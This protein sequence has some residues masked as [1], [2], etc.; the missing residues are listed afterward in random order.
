MAL[1]GSLTTSKYDGRYYKLAWTATQDISTNKSK[2]K[3]TLSCHGGNSS[4]YAERTLKVVVAG[5]TVFSKTSRKERYTG[6]I[7]TGTVTV[8]H[9]TDG[10]KSFSASVKAAVYTS[11]VNCTGSKTFTLDQIPRAATITSAPDFT[12]EDN[13]VLNYS[14]SAGSSVTTLQACIAS[15]DGMT[16]YAPYRDI[17]KTGTSYTFNLTEAEREA[18]RKAC[19]NAKSMTV[20][21]YVKTD[22]DGETYR[23]NLAKT[24]TI[25]NAEPD[26][27][28]TAEATDEL[29][30]SLLGTSQAVI[31]GV[32]DLAYT[33]TA[34]AKKHATITSYKVVNGSA[35]QTTAAG[36]F[37]DVENGNTTA[38][39]T[40]SRGYTRTT[41]ISFGSVI[42]YIYP[43]ATLKYSNVSVEG[44]VDLDL[45][46][47]CYS[48]S[49]LNTPNTTTIE[50]RY[51]PNDGDWSDYIPIEGATIAD[52]GYNIQYT[53]EGLDYHKT[54][55]IEYRVVD[56]IGSVTS[57]YVEIVF[58]PLF[59]W[60]EG[61]F[62][63]NV[64]VIF[65]AG[66]INAASAAAEGV[67]STYDYVIESGADSG[68]RYRKWKSGFIEAWFNEDINIATNTAYGSGF[69]NGGTP[70]YDFPS[71]LFTT[72]P[73][74]QLS[75]E[76]SNAQLYDAHIAA[77]SATRLTYY[78]SS[79][80]AH[81]AST[82]RIQI[83]AYGNT[84]V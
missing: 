39:I 7:D 52:N 72:K 47:K 32:T 27:R 21:F 54:Y 68:W 28:I 15:S 8:S 67:E 65:S 83:Y 4:W 62:N 41:N 12:D 66:F 29:S 57:N 60:G 1:S 73:S 24:L 84:E 61:D 78:I 11:S 44:R 26:A 9:N 2:I 3:W 42:K 50:I 36:T 80:Q 48:G 18:L 20:R 14:N 16:I 81:D 45:S 38:T 35:T 70:Y 33:V 49:F 37:T 56:K 71:N 63:F 22:I 43:T 5:V 76:P 79:M 53:L 34:T 51:K 31:L 46:G 10:T 82:M 30:L 58:M 23:K 17:S 75:V 19:T 69:Y 77:V 6:T 40:D 64:P 25:A 59:D 55:T 13:P 74:V